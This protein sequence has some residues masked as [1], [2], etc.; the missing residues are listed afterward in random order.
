MIVAVDTGGTKTLVAV[1]DTDGNVTNEHKFPTPKDVPLY[2]T[3]LT[4]TIDSLTKDMDITCLSV[5]LPGLIEDGVV[6]EAGNLS[7]HNVDIKTPLEKKYE[8]PVIVENDAN[9]AGLAEARALKDQHVR[10]LYVTVSTGIGIGIITN[11]QIDP[12][13]ARSEGGRIVLEHEG[14]FQQWENFASGK[15]ILKKHGKLASDIEDPAIWYEIALNIA[16]GVM[17]HTPI[18]RPEIL[19]FGGGV[20]THFDKFS[21]ELMSILT[22]NLEHEYI[23]PIVKA[24]HPEK[25]VIYGCY[26]HALDSAAA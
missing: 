21:D 19:I 26:Y 15:A 1:F 16:K 20:G 11:G 9:L 17:V 8:R 23:P 4:E 18:L 24:V 25:A 5:G 12:N 22:K 7:W 6:V 13:Y 2:L 3:L 14:S 10:A